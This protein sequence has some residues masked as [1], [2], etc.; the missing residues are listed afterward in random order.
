MQP[1]INLEKKDRGPKIG[2]Y[3]SLWGFIDIN[4]DYILEPEYDYLEHSK[5]NY[6]LVNKNGLW[7]YLDENFELLFEPKYLAASQFKNGT[8][9]VLMGR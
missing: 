7:G 6:Y 2:E 8:A 5:E 3:L 1:K 4:G 9:M